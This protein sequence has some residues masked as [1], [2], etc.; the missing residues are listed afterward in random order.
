MLKQVTIDLVKNAFEA[1]EVGETVTCH[2]SLDKNSDRCC[3]S[4]I[5]QGTPIAPEILPKLT[6]P[7]VSHKP[8]GT[9]LGLAIVKQIIKFTI[10]N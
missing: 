2:L 7:F 4:V 1:I 6:E 8:G 9:G 10:P 3:V 5:N